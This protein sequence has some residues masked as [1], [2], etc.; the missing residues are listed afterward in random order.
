MKIENLKFISDFTT[1]AYTEYSSQKL[2]VT[3]LVQKGSPTKEINLGD[4]KFVHF[5]NH[6][7]KVANLFGEESE[8]KSTI[9]FLASCGG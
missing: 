8:I 4:W 3:N 2:Y 9:M 1:L 7:E 6:A 5:V